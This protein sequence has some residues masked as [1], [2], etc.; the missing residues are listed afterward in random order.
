M[1][2]KKE[3][4]IFSILRFISRTNLNAELSMKNVLKPG[5][6]MLQNAAAIQ[7]KVVKLSRSY[8][9]RMVRSGVQIFRVM[10][11]QPVSL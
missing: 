6:Q 1:F 10:S 11:V 7:Q 5:G 4:A 9:R 8:F 2:S 3:F